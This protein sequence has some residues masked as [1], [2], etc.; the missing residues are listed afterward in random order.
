MYE[1][2]RIGKSIEAERSVAARGWRGRENEESFLN[3]EG[4]SFWAIKVLELEMMI[5]PH[6]ECTKCN[7]II[8]FK[9]VSFM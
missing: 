6:C 3:G 2:S 7:G 4:V 1:I 5:V 9:M 8:H